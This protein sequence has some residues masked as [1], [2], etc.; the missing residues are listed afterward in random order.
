[1]AVHS[2][3][4]PQPASSAGYGSGRQTQMQHGKSHSPSELWEETRNSDCRDAGRR[5]WSTQCLTQGR[6]HSTRGI[7]PTRICQSRRTARQ[8]TQDGDLD[9]PTSGQGGITLVPRPLGCIEEEQGPQRFTRGRRAIVQLALH[10]DLPFDNRGRKDPNRQNTGRRENSALTCSKSDPPSGD[11]VHPESGIVILRKTF[12][13][14]QV[15]VSSM[16]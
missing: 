12:H 16:T 6:R 14:V 5:P 7:R 9:D 10:G 8:R 11:R 15:A 2:S 1:M 3:L 4:N 13:G